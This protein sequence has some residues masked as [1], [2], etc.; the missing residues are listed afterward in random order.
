MCLY[1]AGWVG[2]CASTTLG[3]ARLLVSDFLYDGCVRVMLR[4]LYYLLVM[5][6]CRRGRQVGADCGGAGVAAAFWFLPVLRPR[7]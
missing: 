5:V 7:S 6:A 3:A 1:D 4:V 2:A